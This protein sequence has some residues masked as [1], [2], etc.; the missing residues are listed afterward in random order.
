M[1]IVADKTIILSVI[2]LI[3]V[4]LSVIV[5]TVVILSVVTPFKFQRKK[6]F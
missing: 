2:V 3:V 4:I 6:V 1:L 5:L